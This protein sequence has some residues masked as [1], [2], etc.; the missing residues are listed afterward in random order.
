MK[1]EKIFFLSA[2]TIE[3]LNSLRTKVHPWCDVVYL[4]NVTRDARRKYFSEAKNIVV[5]YIDMYACLKVQR[6]LDL[7]KIDFYLYPI[8]VIIY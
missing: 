7:V 8:G 6:A 2:T 4:W 5:G 1:I 3:N